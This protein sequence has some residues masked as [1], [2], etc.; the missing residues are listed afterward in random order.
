MFFN[1]LVFGSQIIQFGIQVIFVATTQNSEIYL[2]AFKI[3]YFVYDISSVAPAWFLVIMSE[4][5]RMGIRD[6]FGIKKE[7]TVFV[8]S[9]NTGSG[10]IGSTLQVSNSGT[11]RN[12]SRSRMRLYYI[13]KF[14]QICFI[15]MAMAA[16]IYIDPF[17]DQDPLDSELFE[18]LMKDKVSQRINKNPL[19]DGQLIGDLEINNRADENITDIKEMNP[20]LEKIIE[21]AKAK[22]E[23]ANSGILNQVKS[24]DS[25]MPDETTDNSAQLQRT[26]RRDT[27]DGDDDSLGVEVSTPESSLNSSEDVDQ[28][29]ITPA[30]LTA[31][32]AS[33]NMETNSEATSLEH[34]PEEKDDGHFQDDSDVITLP[35]DDDSLENR[36]EQES[37]EEKR[38]RIINF[39]RRHKREADSVFN[40]RDPINMD[41]TIIGTFRCEKI[42][43]WSFNGMLTSS[44][45]IYQDIA[46]RRH[47]ASLGLF[48]HLIIAFYHLLCHFVTKV[49]FSQCSNR[50]IAVFSAFVWICIGSWS[51][52]EYLCWDRTFDKAPFVPN[53]PP[54]YLLILLYSIIAILILAIEIIDHKGL[55]ANITV[56]EILP[57]GYSHA[58]Q[59]EAEYIKSVIEQ[60]E[61][62]NIAP[63]N[64]Q[65]DEFETKKNGVHMRP[66]EDV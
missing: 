46:A 63:E 51:L 61:M 33:D 36:V 60:I 28:L 4:N 49:P 65:V 13:V 15:L 57:T 3:Q 42:D 29:E 10:A 12:M 43:I 27:P 56:D 31:E 48:V 26:E 34:N 54:F 7:A 50:V 39:F 6:L 16:V 45:N 59:T 21:L 17:C 14:I 52:F 19:D 37:A 25:M 30:A 5:L 53:I 55:F 8:I 32:F 64:L 41:R 35:M 24:P 22:A 62:A 1:F 2:F 38:D 40:M 23:E 58:P 11:P 20:V 47:F 66:L 18:N 44:G 9:E